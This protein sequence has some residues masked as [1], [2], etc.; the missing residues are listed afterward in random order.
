[1]FHYC[2][3]RGPETFI[4]SLK[5]NSKT[6]LGMTM[7]CIMAGSSDLTSVLDKDNGEGNIVYEGQESFVESC[8]TSS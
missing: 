5:I 2:E 3:G 4:R 7:M 8:C 6:K 1:M